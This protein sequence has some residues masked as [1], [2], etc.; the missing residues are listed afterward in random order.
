M[1][2]SAPYDA[3][4]F[5]KI[6]SGSRASARAVMPVVLD[7]LRPRSVVDL[8]CGEGAWLSVVRDLGI[9]DI[10]GIDGEYVDRAGLLISPERFL[11]ADISRPLMIGRRFDLAMSLEVA[12]HVAPERA[13]FYLDNLTALSDAI[14]FSAAVPNQTGVGHVNEQWPEYWKTLFEARGF[15]LI[16]SLRHRFWNDRNVERWYRQNLL[17]YVSQERLRASPALQREWESARHRPLAVVHPAMYAAPSLSALWHMLPG[18]IVRA[19]RRRCERS[20]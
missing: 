6:E 3:R 4:F 5:K 1:S 11:G 2:A 10:L 12:E 13:A 20:A 19:L 16:D 18:T 9:Q 8:G 14:V 7:L 17:L 15:V